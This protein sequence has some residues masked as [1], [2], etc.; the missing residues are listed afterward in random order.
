MTFQQV[1]LAIIVWIF[2]S[3]LFPL[4][5]NA[6]ER[7]YQRE[8]DQVVE[9]ALSFGMA[10]LLRILQLLFILIMLPTITL[11]TIFEITL[12]AQRLEALCN[13]NPFTAHIPAGV[14]AV[15]G[16]NFPNVLRA[17]VSQLFKRG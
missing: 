14:K 9:R 15:L 8:I 13:S 4:L 3:A 5:L 16:R 11:V 2:L 12:G 10:A 7:L 1:L 6:V 17:G